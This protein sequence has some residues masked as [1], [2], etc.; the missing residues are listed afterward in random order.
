LNRKG[1]IKMRRLVLLST[2]VLLAAFAFGTSNTGVAAAATCNTTLN[3]GD[4]IQAAIDSASSGDVICLNPGI[5][6][7]SAKIDI[8]KSITLQ[9]PQAGIDPRPSVGTSRT[10]GDSLAEAIIDGSVGGLSG[11]IVITADNVVIDGVEVRS[12][13]GDLID[14]ESSIPTVGTVLRYNIIDA[15]TGD[16]GIQLRYVENG[17]IEYN[18]VFNIAQDGIN[19]CCGSTGGAIRFNEVHSISSENAAIYVYDATN[20]SIQC[21]LV[22]DVYNNDGIKLGTKGG[23][24]ATLSGGSILYN[25]VYNTAQD[26]IALYMS[27]TLIEGNEIYGSSSENGA[28]YLAFGISD[29]TVTHND[30]HDNTL[31]TGKWGDPGAIMIGTDVDAATVSVTDNNIYSNSPNGLTNKAAAQLDAENNWWGA[32]DGPSGAGT[33]TGDA[34]SSNVDFV[35]WR[36]EAVPM[37]NPCV[38]GDEEGPLTY[39]LTA[40][41]NPVPVSSPVEI[42]AIVDDTDRGDSNIASAEYS[43]DNGISW[44]PMEPIDGDWDEVIESVIAQFSTD[45]PGIYNHTLCARGTDT[46]G[47]TGP[48]TCTDLMLVVYD[49]DGGFVTGGGW[50]WSQ[51]GELGPIYSS[52]PETF[53]GSFPSLGYEATSTD[54]AGDHIAF[55]ESGGILDSVTVSLTDWACENDFDYVDG[56]WVPN[57]NGSA[58]EACVSTPGSGFD[59]PI[60]L[61]IYAVDSSS[62]EPAV[63]SLIA[64]KTETF[65]IPYRPSWDSVNCTEAGE[66][67]ET[68]IPFGGKWYD[69]V[70]GACVHGYAFNIDFDFSA[71]DIVLPE[72]V[73]YGVAYNTA[74][75]G[76]TP[77]G[78]S[79]P[80]S[81]LNLSLDTSVPI[82]GTNVEPDTMFWDTSYGPFYCDGGAGGTDTFRRDAGCW[83]TY[84]PVI[85]FNTMTE[86]AYKPDP[87]LEGKATFGFVSK[88][89]KGADIPTGN[90]EFQFQAG[91]L[92]FHST[93]YDWLVVTGSDY[94]KFKGAGTINGEG[95]Y[96][97]MLWAGD[98]DP[99]TFRMKI[100]WEDGGGEHV[101]YDNGMDQ[102]ISGGNIVVHK[103]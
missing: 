26:G 39:D 59:H 52:I 6:S 84:T 66:T 100:W 60:T 102:A 24:D 67:P 23:D 1:A 22:Y 17:V 87:T 77:I 76:H 8:D 38:P 10:P 69:P 12:G 44:N 37:T 85:Q 14:S 47:N 63:G 7:P 46:E 73:I 83:G 72:E 91:D 27:D 89:K 5:Y 81:S 97:F 57:R 75:H 4:D 15:A 25:T 36:T 98:G 56:T 40:N 64:Q 92:N 49:P 16:E 32:S 55:A 70:L 103:K 33:G 65:F 50:I 18:H 71:D 93:S 51:G 31:N 68:D 34:V 74:N 9:G 19:M 53:P 96:K 48:E 82:V 94:A 43:L 45:S 41:P 88:Y 80:Y 13:S 30:V 35:P 62:G 20:M 28:I 29:V 99:D 58:G 86:G 78:V 2:V 95:D 101:V 42:T 54:E 79:G 11:I 21:N 61:N 90:T 3:P